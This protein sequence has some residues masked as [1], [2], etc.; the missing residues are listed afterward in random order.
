ME[1]DAAV[2]L[3]KGESARVDAAPDRGHGPADVLVRLAG[4]S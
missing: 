2:A 1:G 4:G 3:D